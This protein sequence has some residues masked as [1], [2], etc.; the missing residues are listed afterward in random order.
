[1]L[2]P[3]NEGAE[4]G[5]TGGFREQAARDR[6]SRGGGAMTGRGAIRGRDFAL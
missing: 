1:M 5:H 2:G 3:H 6:L 4:A